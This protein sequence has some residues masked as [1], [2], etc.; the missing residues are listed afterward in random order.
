MDEDPL[1][2]VRL[3]IGGRSI[4]GAMSWGEPKV[5]AP[6]TDTSPF[7]GLP[8]PDDVSVTAQVRAQPD[9][10]L[11]QRVIAQLADGTPLVVKEAA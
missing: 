7:F 10:T 4:G 6:F 2:P 9:P 11:S 5:L 3:R 1:M 8:I